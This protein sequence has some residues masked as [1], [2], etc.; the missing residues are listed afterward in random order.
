LAPLV[1]R[2]VGDVDAAI[3]VRG[4]H[5]MDDAMREH[6]SGPRTGMVILGLLSAVALF[7]A[8]VGLYGVQAY[9]VA[10]RAPEIGIR[11]ALGASTAGVVRQ[12]LGEGM[13]TVTIATGIGIV[14]AVIV[15]NALRASVFGAAAGDPLTLA[16]VAALVLAVSTLACI[17]PAWRAARIAPSEALRQQ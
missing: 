3:P 17:A 4:L 11:M 2:A 7:L 6:L 9:L 13:R 1:R 8:V 14:L 5:T 15:T 10:R 12:V 16:A